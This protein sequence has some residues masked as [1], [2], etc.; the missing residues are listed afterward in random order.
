[1]NIK[2]VQHSAHDAAELLRSLANEKRLMLLCQ[3]VEGEKSVGALSQELGL[4]QS[5]ASQQL[6]I[7]RKD[8]LVQTRRDGQ[9]IYYALQGDEAKRVIEVLHGIYCCDR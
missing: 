6:S 3:L 5:N 8:G 4:S 1:M 9:S 2:E 7:L